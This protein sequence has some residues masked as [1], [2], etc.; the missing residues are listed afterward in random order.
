MF[1][2]RHEKKIIAYAK[3]MTQIDVIAIVFALQIVHPFFLR[4][5]NF[6]ACIANSSICVRPGGKLGKLFSL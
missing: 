3:T 5:M 6:Q 2:R 1:E 4:D